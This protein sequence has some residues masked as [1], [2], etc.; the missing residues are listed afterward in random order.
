LWVPVVAQNTLDDV[1]L[2]LAQV[3][4]AVR[5]HIVVR[6]LV[7]RR[8]VEELVHIESVL[9]KGRG[10]LTQANHHL[11][12][13]AHAHGN[14]AH[15]AGIGRQLPSVGLSVTW[16]SKEHAI[17]EHTVLA[18]TSSSGFLV[19]S[20]KECAFSLAGEGHTRPVDLV[21][22]G[23]VAH[24][25]YRDL[26]GYSSNHD[27]LLLQVSHHSSKRKLAHSPPHIPIHRLESLSYLPLIR[28]FFP[29]HPSAR[30]T[31]LIFEIFFPQPKN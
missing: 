16:R 2:A 11:Q 29:L 3:K 19:Q 25:Q 12:L 15:V 23:H 10:Q 20:L 7:G 4:E 9:H 8:S 27:K 30:L 28:H 14:V 6:K 5:C 18:Y 1:S 24:D 22:F 26:G 21:H 13:V 31:N 17:G